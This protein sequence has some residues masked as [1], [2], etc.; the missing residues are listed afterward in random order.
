VSSTPQNSR[1]WNTCTINHV[2]MVHCQQNIM[3]CCLQINVVMQSLWCLL[4]TFTFHLINLFK[5]FPQQR[6]GYH[7]VPTFYAFKCFHY[8]CGSHM[9]LEQ[10][11]GNLELCPHNAKGTCGIKNINTVNYLNLTDSQNIPVFCKIFSPVH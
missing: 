11:R 3:L 2:R 10:K 9:Y 6:A 4:Y 8:F 1:S 5:K 7:L